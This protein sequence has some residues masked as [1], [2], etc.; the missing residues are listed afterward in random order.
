MHVYMCMRMCM[1]MHVYMCMCICARTACVGPLR[2]NARAGDGEH[3][4]RCAAPVARARC[5]RWT[6]R[7]HRRGREPGR[8]CVCT[9]GCMRARICICIRIYVCICVCLCGGGWI[10]VCPRTPARVHLDICTCVCVSVGVG[11]CVHARGCGCVSAR[12]CA[13]IY[14]CS[15]TYVQN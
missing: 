10:C 15:R 14:F 8:R 7:A 12:L 9:S 1:Y 3:A 5:A 11:I 4:V 13:C 2:P 6:G